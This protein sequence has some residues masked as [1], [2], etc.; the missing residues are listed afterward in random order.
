VVKGRR[1]VV[2]GWRRSGEGGRGG[3]GNKSSEER[4]VG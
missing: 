4:A 1:E 2:K 3:G